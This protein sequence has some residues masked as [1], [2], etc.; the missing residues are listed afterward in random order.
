MQLVSKK[1]RKAADAASLADLDEMYYEDVADNL[2][3]IMERIYQP[4]PH[5]DQLVSDVDLAGTVPERMWR[6]LALAQD[7]G[8]VCKYGPCCVEIPR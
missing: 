4:L 1:T 2:P 6:A 8:G 7:V 3:D 5:H